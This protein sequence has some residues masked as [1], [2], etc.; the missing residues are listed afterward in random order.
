MIPGSSAHSRPNIVLIV[1]DD[2][3]YG[4]LG[5]FNYGASDTPALDQ[6]VREGLSLTQHYSASPVCAPARASLLTGRYPHRTGAIDT[7]E[8]RGLDRLALSEIT[9]ADCLRN[10]GYATGLIGKW[11]NGALD[12]RYHPNARGFDEFAGFCGGWSPYVDYHLDVNGAVRKSDGTYIT[13]VFTK[14]A[15]AFIRRH[16][17]EPFL[18]MLTYSAPHFPFE[19]PEDDLA[20]FRDRGAFTTVVSQIYGMIRCMDRGVGRVLDQLDR[21]HIA[22]NTIVLFTSDNGPQFSGAGDMSSHR[23][24]CG[25]AGA[26]LSV[27]EGG[28]RVPAVVR[29]PAR[30]AGGRQV[31]EM[32]H[33]ADWLPTLLSAAGVA[34]PEGVALDGI[35]VLPA[36]AGEPA[37][38][39]PERFWQWNRYTPVGKS[40]AAMHDGDWKLVRPQ[41]D[42]VMRVSNED[43]VIDI[44]AKYHPERYSDIV[45]EAEPPRDVPA[46]HPPRLFNLRSD[47]LEQ[48]DLAAEQPERVARME[49]ALT[50][51][52]EEVEGERRRIPDART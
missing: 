2:M 18:L 47:P 1:A 40:N 46:A 6:L 50:R 23:Y 16:A 30:L 12:R 32:V 35:D 22:E 8:M 4:D 52:F 38:A 31:H 9:L 34:P 33:F 51:W 14:E 3:G 48:H 15:V 44:D 28:I 11:H 29:W 24:N 21:D 20:V 42:E 36:L 7:L 25:F 17:R 37:V 13:D 26:K 43:L 5:C 19:S 41:I 49:A 27:Y 39:P 45:R 10:A